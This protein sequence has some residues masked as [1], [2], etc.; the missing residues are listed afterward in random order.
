MEF[1]L[2]IIQLLVFL[3]VLVIFFFFLYRIRNFNIRFEIQVAVGEKRRSDVKENERGN[4]EGKT[5]APLFEGGFEDGAVSVKEGNVDVRFENRG[6]NED[7][8]KR[9]SDKEPEEIGSD[10]DGRRKTSFGI[11]I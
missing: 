1:R 2:E 8:N 3:L 11:R 6:I 5:G 4:R 7:F 9:W 10:G